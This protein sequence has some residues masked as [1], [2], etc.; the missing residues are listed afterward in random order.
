MMTTAHC[1]TRGMHLPLPVIVKSEILCKYTS[2]LC[3]QCTNRACYCSCPFSMADVFLA[4][5]FST[6]NLS[7]REF[8]TKSIS[9]IRGCL[10]QQWQFA[11]WFR[12]A[13]ETAR[14]SRID[15]IATN[16][17]NRHPRHFTPRP[18]ILSPET[19]QRQEALTIC[20]H[21]LFLQSPAF[22]TARLRICKSSP[23]CTTLSPAW[24]VFMMKSFGQRT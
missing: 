9:E 24:R 6:S 21:A 10:P 7:L 13:R 1:G 4:S 16:L 22:K 18:K 3:I 15:G 8:I 2:R 12:G 19:L 11:P 5:R 20:V 14:C 17:Q 23:A